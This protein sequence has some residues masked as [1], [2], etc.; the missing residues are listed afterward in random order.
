MTVK[1]IKL[2]F[3][4]TLIFQLTNCQKNSVNENNNSSVSRQFVESKYRQFIVGKW[5]GRAWSNGQDD[6]VIMT[7]IFQPD[8]KMME[9]D[10]IL[11]GVSPVNYEKQIFDYEF[12]G[13]D[14]IKVSKYPDNLKIRRISN[15]EIEFV[16]YPQKDYEEA[17]DIIYSA[18][19]RRVS[20]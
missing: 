3:I 11:N 17:V 15:D 13:D 16:K 20:N 4:S 18:R 1:F 10:S 9:I 2:L 8:G 14:V 19:F 6:V 12:I 5:E 7:I